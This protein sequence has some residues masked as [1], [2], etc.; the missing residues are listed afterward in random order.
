MK[1][2]FLGLWI[3]LFTVSLGIST[4]AEEVTA[5]YVDPVTGME[6]VFVYGG[7]FR[8]GDVFG[9]G[10]DDEK[11]VHEVCVSDFFIG[12]YEVTQAQWEQIMGNNPSS[13]KGCGKDCPVESVSYNMVQEYIKKLNSMTGKRYR[14][15]TEA[16]WEYVARS[17]G[18]DEKW[19]GTNVEEE[20]KEYAWYSENAETV[21]HKVGLKKPNGLGIYDM[22]G[23]V[24][25]WCLDGYQ[26]DFYKH[27]QQKN[28][29]A[30]S[31]NKKYVLRGGCYYDYKNDIRTMKR[32]SDYADVVDNGF[33]FR[34]VL[35]A[36]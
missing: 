27:S 24:I 7:C 22:S 14:L 13:N 29:L 2:I 32:F 4:S 1:K 36:K 30:F 6:F 33:G 28:P 10:E 23:N 20:V 11:P 17:G 18:R 3:V 9:S 35:P 34:L 19:A 21:I 15:P 25:E 26:N 5:N 16:E 8:M 31:S 12:K